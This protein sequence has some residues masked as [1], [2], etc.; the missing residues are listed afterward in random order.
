MMSVG[1]E[2]DD[3]ILLK[4][5][6]IH[7]HHVFKNVWTQQLDEVILV[8]QEAGNTHDKQAVALLKVD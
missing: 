8:S 4:E 1:G 3:S 2:P 7:G 5:S 6:I